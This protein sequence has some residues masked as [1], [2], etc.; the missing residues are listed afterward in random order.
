MP[1][2]NTLKKM[3]IGTPL[4]LPLR[5]LIARLSP[6]SAGRRSTS[7]WA[8]RQDRD[9]RNLDV[10][11]PRLIKPDA[12]CVDIGANVGDYLSQFVALAPRGRHLAC[13]PLPH[14]ARDLRSKF[15]M[16]QVHECALSDTS[17]QA[18]FNYV[19]GLPDWSGL[20]TQS[21]PANVKV[22]K[23]PVEIKRLDDL[24]GP[25]QQVDFIK[26]DVEGAEMGVFRGGAGVIK[27]CRP[28]ILF[29]HARV[30]TAEY[31]TTPEMVH[32]FLCGECGL[33]MYSLDGSGPHTREQFAKIYD[34]SHRNNYDR[35]SETNFLA[36]TA[37]VA[38]L[39]QR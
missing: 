2:V 38:I 36:T 15:P 11:L 1:I 9:G 31:A 22:E 25:D 8:L 6:G 12:T 21:Y 39:K 26:V 17:G 7:D 37:D 10:L 29:E 35:T 24:I 27:R 23:I 4:E 33:K 32:D 30:H 13:E 34:R 5:R 14:L 19:H 28:H 3:V 18:T 20:K 16:V